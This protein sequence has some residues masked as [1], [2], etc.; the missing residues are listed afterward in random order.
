MSF[1]CLVGQVFIRR[2]FYWVK[3][4]SSSEAFLAATL[5]VVLLCSRIT[6]GLGLSDTLGAFVG[7]VLVAETSYKHQ[8]EA[9][10]APFRGMLLGLFFVTV[11]FSLDLKLLASTWA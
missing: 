7:G 1:I 11:G 9:D 8:V 5:G 2:L 3:R 6:E 4:S 10:I